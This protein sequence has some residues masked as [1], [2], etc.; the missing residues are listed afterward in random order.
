MLKE[1]RKFLVKVFLFIILFLT[2]DFP[3][4]IFFLSH[5]QIKQKSLKNDKGGVLNEIH[6]FPKI[7]VVLHIYFI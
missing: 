7:R 2:P 1:E 6:L 3:L 4:Y 5:H